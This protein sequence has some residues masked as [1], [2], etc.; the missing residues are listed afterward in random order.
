MSPEMSMYCL[1]IFIERG[2]SHLFEGI[3]IGGSNIPV[4]STEPWC[5]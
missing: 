4:A 1:H 3:V 5:G 2:F